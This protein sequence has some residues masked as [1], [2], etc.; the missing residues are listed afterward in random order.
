MNGLETVEREHIDKLDFVNIIVRLMWCLVVVPFEPKKA[1]PL[2]QHQQTEM[3]ALATFL[4][5]SSS[6]T[7]SL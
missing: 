5:Y 2:W 1:N 6:L 7:Y 4:S 3:D